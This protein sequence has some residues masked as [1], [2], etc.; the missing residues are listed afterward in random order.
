MHTATAA[1]VGVNIAVEI[2]DYLARVVDVF[3]GNS[4]DPQDDFIR[5]R[6]QLALL[7]NAIALEGEYFVAATSFFSECLCV[8]VDCVSWIYGR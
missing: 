4:L 8:D 2:A 6:R 1:P 3:C 5:R 7:K